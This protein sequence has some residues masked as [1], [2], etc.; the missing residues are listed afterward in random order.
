MRTIAKDETIRAR[1]ARARTSPLRT[2]RELTVG[3]AGLMRLVGY[4]LLTCLLGPLPGGLGF[5]SRKWLYP[6]LF[7]ATGSG[8]VLGRNVVLRHPARMKLGDNV[9]VDDGCVLDARGTPRGGFV[10]GDGVLIN[11]NSI[12]QA[13]G[14]P[15]TI[16]ERSSIGA[17]SVI[18]S[19]SGVEIGRTVLAAGGCYLSAGSY[20]ITDLSRPVMDGDVVSKGPIR[21]GDGVWIG[22]AAVIL[23]GVTIGRD[24]VIGAGAVVTGDVPERAIVAGVP[25]RRIGTRG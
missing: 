25:A 2:Y 11:R 15:V 13:K 3:D 6:G 20:P 1:M 12:V 17:N 8:L 5:L 4:E 10:L 9:T 18:V 22:T 21:I 23:D 24:A 7:A 19:V 16:G 14:G